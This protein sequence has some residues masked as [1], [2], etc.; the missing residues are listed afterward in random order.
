MYV[1]ASFKKVSKS[2][3]SLRV[4]EEQGHKDSDSEIA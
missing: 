4:H 1:K 3:R 2:S